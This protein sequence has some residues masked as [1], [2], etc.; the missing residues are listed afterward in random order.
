MTS[1]QTKFALNELLKQGIK[2][3]EILTVIC[4]VKKG[5]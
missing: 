5:E 2:A 3:I 4:Q 1:E